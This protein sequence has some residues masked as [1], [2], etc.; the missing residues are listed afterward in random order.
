MNAF[1]PGA[2][3]VASGGAAVGLPEAPAG[4]TPGRYEIDTSHS[5]ITFKTRHLFGLAPVRGRFAVR[6]GTVDIAEPLAGSSIYV[7]VD[8]ASFGTGNGQRDKTVRSESLLDVARY[9]VLTFRSEGVDLSAVTGSLTV[10][11]VT[12]PIT[13]SVEA[14]AVAAGSFTVRA[15]TRID[16][17][18]FG[19]TAYRGAA[20]RYLDITAEIRCVSA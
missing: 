4:L 3:Q 1:K 12:M 20:G 16:R 18:E 17:T 11:D 13:W 6:A 15:G 19:V 5:A 9:P 8:S 7:Q 14:T 10:R 2:A